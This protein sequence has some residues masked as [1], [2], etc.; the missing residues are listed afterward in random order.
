M[1]NKI[2]PV[3]W[4][5][6]KNN[7]VYYNEKVFLA[8]N[9][10]FQADEIYYDLLSPNKDT[11]NNIKQSDLKIFKP[12]YRIGHIFKSDDCFFKIEEIL[13]YEEHEENSVLYAIK[14]ITDSG[15][16]VK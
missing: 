8:K 9:P 7:F 2:P 1:K 6:Y 4:V 16:D 3:A 11:I 12:R 14:E 10:K 13:L 5:N 15:G